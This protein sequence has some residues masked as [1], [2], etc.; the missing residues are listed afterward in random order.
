MNQ[1]DL[2]GRVA[3]ITGGARGIGFAVAE[4][5]LRSGGSVALWDVE[6]GPLEDARGRLSSLGHVTTFVVDV[7]REEVVSAATK[8]TAAAHG[9]IDILI[10]NAGITG[11]NAVA[12]ELSPEIW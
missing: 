8:G 12:W 1:L 4:R 9:K 5:V 11:G 6:A 3:V 7:A 10:N 2:M